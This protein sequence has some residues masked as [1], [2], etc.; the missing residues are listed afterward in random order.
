MQ[1][2]SWQ[3]YVNLVAAD[4]L[5]PRGDGDGAGA[6]ATGQRLA[7][8]ALPDPRL[9]LTRPDV[10]RDLE[11]DALREQAVVFHR[12]ADGRQWEVGDGR[13]EEA[14]GVAG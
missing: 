10:A 2:A 1:R 6:G 11:V 4:A 9:E 8:A 13:I 3:R 5:E 14:D 12:R 7:N